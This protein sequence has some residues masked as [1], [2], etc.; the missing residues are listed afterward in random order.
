M[1]PKKSGTSDITAQ[2][3][4]LSVTTS[5]YVLGQP[6]GI[7]LSPTVMQL[8]KG[9]TTHVVTTVISEDNTKRAVS[10]A[11]TW[12]SSDPNIAGVSEGT[13]SGVAPGATTITLARRGQSFSRQVQ[14][15]NVTLTSIVPGTSLESPIV[16]GQLT[17]ISA[18]GV[19]TQG[20]RQDVT[21]FLKFALANEESGRIVT[22]AG[23]VVT[24]VKPGRA[25]IDVTGA[26]GTV[27]QG[28][29]A[30]LAVDVLDVP[31]SI[32][33]VGPVKAS[34]K[35]AP[36]PLAVNGLIGT[37]ER[38]VSSLAVVRV[39]PTGIV[40]VSGTTIIP[41]KAGEVKLTAKVGAEESV[42]AFTVVD[43]PVAS[44]AIAVAENRSETL[45]AGQSLPLMG[46]A[47]FEPDLVQTVTR[48]VLWLSDAPAVAVVDNAEQTSGTVTGLSA[49][50][51]TIQA[52]YR[53]QLVGSKTITVT[54]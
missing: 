44:F 18:E 8:A 32:K 46:V 2:V 30:Q 23:R 45:A 27:A 3:D 5:V 37:V 13:V 35:G 4:G 21:A 6:V 48:Q 50:T 17:S 11:V 28:A 43:A 33:W 29:R 25:L 54:P 26:E 9:T 15:L 12:A 22:L 31:S 40:G 36:V 16:V 7:Q 10:G 24:A 38:D 20:H 1:I 52:Y 53:G 49:G 41:I 19:F 14:V 47:T 42:L 39:D 51:A 34:L